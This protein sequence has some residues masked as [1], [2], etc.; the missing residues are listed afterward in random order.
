MVD[1]LKIKSA[2]GIVKIIDLESNEIL[3]DQQNAIHFGNITMAIARALAGDRTGIVRWMAFGN[4]G[5]SINENGTIDYRVPNVSQFRDQSASLYNETYAKDIQLNDNSNFIEVVLSSVNYA[6]IKM[7]VTLQFGEPTTQDIVDNATTDSEPFIFD[8]IGIK[9]NDGLTSDTSTQIA[10][11]I[12]HPIQKAL[13]RS[14]QV[15]YIIR[16]QMG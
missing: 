15:T 4:G 12:F 13:N 11:I 5:T 7:V 9:I 14:I 16:V 8:E 10:H 2:I 6:D 1:N 3:L